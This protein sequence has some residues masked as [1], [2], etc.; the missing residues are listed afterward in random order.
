MKYRK[1][2]WK[3]IGIIVMAICLLGMRL[4]QYTVEA[5]QTDIK[6]LPQNIVEKQNAAVKLIVSAV[7][8]DQKS[9]NIRQGTGTLVGMKGDSGETSEIVL[10]NDK[11]IRV[12]GSELNNIRLMNGLPVET[13]PGYS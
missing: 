6:E 5:A 3:R 7:T 10:T 9:Y 2:M 11:L 12:E 13:E 4:P 8:S 1:N